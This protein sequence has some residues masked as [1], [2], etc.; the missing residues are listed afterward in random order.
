MNKEN[1]MDNIYAKIFQYVYWFLMLNICFFLTTLPLFISIFA[2]SIQLENLV[3]FFVSSITLGPAIRAVMGC[4]NQLIETKDISVFKD[5]FFYLKSH[6]TEHVV[7]WMVY[8][9][10]LFIIISDILMF[11]MNQLFLAGVPLFVVLAVLLTGLMINTYYFR[12]KN[13]D[14]KYRLIIK[15]SA[16]CTLKKWWYTILNSVLF[17]L[18]ILL[19]FLKPQ[20][21]FFITP[22]LLI[23]LILKNCKVLY[24]QEVK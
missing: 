15:L 24:K 18:I 17:G 7:S 23:F 14:H 2:L 13:P 5:Y 11:V 1:F 22:S 10:M 3:L 9:L 12:L 6:F 16:Y 19:M 20:F 21:G 8:D 4:V